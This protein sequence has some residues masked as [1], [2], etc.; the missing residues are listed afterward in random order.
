MGQGGGGLVHH[1]RGAGL[2]VIVIV[3]L[4]ELERGGGQGALLLGVHHLQVRIS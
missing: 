3:N 1:Y 4:M 2:L